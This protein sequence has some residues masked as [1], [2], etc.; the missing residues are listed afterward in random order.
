MPFDN[1]TREPQLHW[2]AEAA[3]LLIADELNARGVPAIRRAERV[4]AFEQL[5]LPAAASLSRATVIKVGQVVQASEVI[6]GSVRLAG[7]DLVLEAHGVRI[8]VGRVQ[9][10]VSERGPL[11]EVVELFERLSAKIASH[12]PLRGERGPRP[13]L[14]AF[15][16]YVKG[17]M[18]ESAASRATFLEDA[19]RLHPEYDRA[20]IALWAVRHDQADHEAALAAIKSVPDTST[21]ARRAKFFEAISL[22]ELERFDE[23]FD[24]FESA[25]SGA[26]P[27]F[28]AAALNN[29]GVVQL[30]RAAPSPKGEPT[31]F[32][33]RAADADPGDSD[34]LFNLGYAYVLERNP[35]GAIYWLREALRRDPGDAEAHYVLSA[36]LQASGSSVEATRERELARQLS[37]RLEELEKRAASDKVTVARGMERLR[38]DPELRAGL[39]SEEMLVT[40]AQREQQDL[41]SFHLERGRRL[42]ES[43]EDREAMSELRRAVYLSPYEAQAHLLMGRIHLRAGR[44]AEAVEALKI[45]IW[46]RETVDARI[47]LADAYLR[48]QNVAG[49]RGELEKALIL[50]P[51]SVEAKRMLASLPVK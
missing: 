10:A 40:S 30:R 13:P 24:A 3:S 50:D 39:R 2:I 48:Q 25:S 33:T 32:L 7:E 23:A 1:P 29:M 47:A 21:L 28:A 20:H 4:N 31:Y 38:E 22:L 27:A 42:Y 19:I 15:E 16:A 51:E 14:G 18:A 35:K 9:P 44:P 41:A 36:A 43:E 5:Q 45:S 49:A 12:A 6:V 26:S 17:L 8:D 34:I 37:S 11:A 46:S